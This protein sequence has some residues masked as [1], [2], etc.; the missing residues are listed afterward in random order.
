M[1]GPELSL[2][3]NYE[4]DSQLFVFN[5]KKDGELVFELRMNVEQFELLSCDMIRLI[6]HVNLQQIKDYN[7]RQA[8]KLENFVDPEKDQTC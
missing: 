5:F 7:E 4:N 3:L 1:D 6:K 2:G 8:N